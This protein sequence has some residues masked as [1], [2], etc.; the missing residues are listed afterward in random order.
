MLLVSGLYQLLYMR[1][2]AYAAVSASVALAPD[3]GKPWAA[4]L[5][6]AVLRN[7]E[8]QRGTLLAGIEHKPELIYSHPDWLLQ[9]LQQDWPQ[10]W[11]NIAEA[12]N[13]HPPQSL[14]VNLARVA[15]S[16]YLQQLRDAGFAAEPAR[17]IASAITLAQ[18]VSV[19]QLP[20]FGQGLVSVQDAA[21]QLAAPL[22]DLQP[23]QQV[24]DA[25]AAP[26]GKSCHILE[27]MHQISL[28]ALDNDAVRLDK[29]RQ[30]LQRLQLS[31]TVM[32]GD[33][34]QPQQWWDGRRFDRILLDAPCSASGVIRRHPDI[35]LLRRNSDIDQFAGYQA[36]LL[37]RLWPLLQPGGK[38]LYATC[39]VFRQENSDI[40][41]R[42]MEAHR[43]AREHCLEH[44]GWG[45]PCAHGRQILPGEAGMDGF[46]Y[47]CLVK[48]TGI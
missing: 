37:E 12:D 43:D 39:S 36:R 26:G 6:N 1:T 41:Q 2:P 9:R 15:R 27:Q 42:F 13:G 16:D 24:L 28:L 17:Y 21:A 3:M 48:H 8:R 23:G 32:T 4:K 25:C 10:H 29:L 20:G 38:L 33:A 46:Y 14:R 18:P 35:K 40:V 7:F 45:H 5:I 22:L 34:G 31:A 47:A 11:Q 30:N 44:S 19:N